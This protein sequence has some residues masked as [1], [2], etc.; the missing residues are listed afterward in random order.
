MPNQ[1]AWG[2]GGEPFPLTSNLPLLVAIDAATRYIFDRCTERGIRNDAGVV[3]WNDSPDVPRLM[4]P[5]F[6]AVMERLKS[7]CD[8]RDID[9]N[10]LDVFAGLERGEAGTYTSGI[11]PSWGGTQAWDMAAYNA[12]R[13]LTRLK[14][15]LALSGTP[16]PVDNQAE[17]SITNMGDGWR[18][19][20][21]GQEAL[22]WGK[23]VG[24]LAK[25]LSRPNYGWTVAELKGDPERKLEGIAQLRGMP[26][27][28]NAAVKAIRKRMAEI[29]DLDED[30][31]NERLQNEKADLLIQLESSSKHLGSELRGEY[32]NIQKQIRTLKND[33]LKTGM[34]QLFRHLEE[35]YQT[36]GTTFTFR[37]SPP[38][39]SPT[40]TF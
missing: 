22:H 27:M 33:K 30:G 7:E 11:Q 17:R 32:T 28:D 20:F 13:T 1:P 10:P 2:T 25:I 12:D 18:I 24:Y 19:R 36:D 26:A 21:D 35:C 3:K 4:A 23:A 5:Q 31:A 16:K 15:K 8:R 29:E 38:P 9:S 34:P 37:Y 6:D 14:N 40:W 39:G